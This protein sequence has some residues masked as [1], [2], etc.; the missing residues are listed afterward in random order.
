MIHD[1]GFKL[2]TVGSIFAASLIAETV[3]Y[4]IFI[5][6]LHSVYIYIYRRDKPYVIE[7]SKQDEELWKKLEWDSPFLVGKKDTAFTATYAAPGTEELASA[8]DSPPGIF[9][10]LTHSLTHLHIG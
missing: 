8:L 7:G 6:D 4:Q 10:G 5:C 2:I 9:Q 3:H 1:I